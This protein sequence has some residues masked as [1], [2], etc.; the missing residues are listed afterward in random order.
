ML[1]IDFELT[2][3]KHVLWDQVVDELDSADPLYLNI[4]EGKL[5]DHISVH[6]DQPMREEGHLVETLFKR[7]GALAVLTET[8]MLDQRMLLSKEPILIAEDSGYDE[9]RNAREVM[10][11]QDLLNAAGRAGQRWS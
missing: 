7:S 8:P 4:K 3:E 10:E 6:H 1:E 11:A 9:K 2:K 5:I